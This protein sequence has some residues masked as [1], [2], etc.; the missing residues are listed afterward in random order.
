MPVSQAQVPRYRLHKPSGRAVVTLGGRDRYL[1]AY[2][3]EESRGEYQRLVAEW[4]AG[5]SVARVGGTDGLTINEVMLA[6]VTFAQSY[7]RDADGRPTR[8]LETMR[9]AF[10]P[11]KA[12][13]G[14]TAASDFGPMS[15]KAVRQQLVQAGL[16][17]T[18]INQRIGYVR[19]MFRWAGEEQLVSPSV[20]HGLLCVAGLK[21]NRSEARETEPV[22]PVPDAH[23][24][25]IVPFLPPTVRAMLGLQRLTGMRSGELVRIRGCDIET[26]GPVWLYRPPK[27]KTAYLGRKRLIALGSQCQALIRPFLTLNPAAPLFSPKQAQ[28][29]RRRAMRAARKTP[30]QPSQL[31]RVKRRRKREPGESYDTRSYY[32]ALRYAMRAASKGGALA[33]EEFW[34]PHQLRHS[35]ASRI[36]R[37]EGLDAARAFL[38]HSKPDVTAHYAGLDEGTAVRVAARF[39]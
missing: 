15:L 23:V 28:E 4:L 35:A 33:K 3:S 2:G 32:A 20:Y 16:A 6:Y 17:R 11:L 22:S 37:E 21:R 36:Q 10:R 27:H 12:M 7:Y 34:H 24:D 14:H 30:V 1:G 26:T 8:E 31:T 18:V 29:E 19:R 13:Y 25:A 9:L 38:G 5:G 39:A